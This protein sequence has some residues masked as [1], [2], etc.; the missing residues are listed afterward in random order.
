M[1]FRFLR[2]GCANFIFC[3]L[4]LFQH[5]ACAVSP[6][7]STFPEGDKLQYDGAYSTVWTAGEKPLGFPINDKVNAMTAAME[8]CSALGFPS[9]NWRLEDGKIWLDSLKSCREG[10]LSASAIY[11]TDGPLWAS[12]LTADIFTHRGEIL[13]SNSWPKLGIFRKTLILHVQGGVVTKI[14][15][16]DNSND[17]RIPDHSAE[18][19]YYRALNGEVP[20]WL[21]TT[22]IDKC[23]QGPK[24]ENP[25]A[26][27]VA[28][29]GKLR[30]SIDLSNPFAG[31]RDSVTGKMRG[32]GITYAVELAQRLGIPVE[33]VSANSLHQSI[34]DLQ[35]NKA[36]IGFFIGSPPRANAIRMVSSKLLIEG[37]FTVPASAR[38]QNNEDV[39]IQGATIAVADGS[40][41][42][43]FVERALKRASLVRISPSID[44][45]HAIR[46]RGVSAVAGMQFP[47]NYDVLTSAGLQVLARPF[48]SQRLSIGVPKKNGRDAIEY[49]TAFVQDTKDST[50]SAL[51]IQYHLE[52]MAQISKLRQYEESYRSGNKGDE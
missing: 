22:S 46:N 21:S 17:P 41:Y 50:L 47:L 7:V 43:P 34:K 6:L 32:L 9:A 35:S 12:W 20:A 19:S 8:H 3:L 49:L 44:V 24:Q 29:M 38:F 37:Y 23:L 15:E 16:Q 45:I 39:D 27:A 2:L 18:K 4:I 40:I 36:D 10:V 25:I 48:M 30:V 26:R 31:S 33:L 42:Q 14:S 1:A 52:D 11:G 51:L 28:P 13:C 5:S